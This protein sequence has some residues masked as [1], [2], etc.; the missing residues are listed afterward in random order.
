MFML[1]ES[2]HDYLSSEVDVKKLSSSE[3]DIIL[4]SMSIELKGKEIYSVGFM[5]PQS[6]KVIESNVFQLFLID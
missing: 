2:F 1:L 4:E 5:I 6:S 3:T